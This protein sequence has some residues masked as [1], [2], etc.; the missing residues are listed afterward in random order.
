[1][2]LPARV[3]DP[4]FGVRAQPLE[5][6]RADLEAAGAAERLH[7]D[8]A[9]VFQ[10]RRVATEYQLLHGA[11]VDSE[12]VDRQ[13]IARWRRLQP[14]G[15]GAPHTLEERHFAGVIGVDTDAKVDLAWIRIGE[16]RFGDAE[17]GIGGRQ[18]HLR[19]QRRRM[20]SVHRLK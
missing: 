8:D 1:V 19:Q 6:V 11:V 4:H 14:V 17:D 3:A 16:E 18:R 20:R 2:V 10:R 7:G 9:F 12:A 5:K 15:F 13:V